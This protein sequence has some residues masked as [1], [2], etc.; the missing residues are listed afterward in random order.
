MSNDINHAAECAAPAQTPTLRER[1]MRRLFP[2][3][4]LHAPDQ[5]EAFPSWIRTEVYILTDWK[6]RL[7]LLVSGRFRVTIFTELEADPGATRT[8]TV[9]WVAQPET[10][11]EP[12]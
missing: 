11:K 12:T 6:D 9:F 4:P 8:K 5:S 3:Q 2:V 10:G 7:R 1:L